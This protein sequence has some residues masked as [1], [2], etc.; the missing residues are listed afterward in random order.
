MA[1][2]KN[3]PLPDLA[4]R[5]KAIRLAMGLN[6]RDF[7]S[8]LGMIQ[9]SYNNSETGVSVPGMGLAV[10]LADRL[11]RLD[12]RW[13]LTGEGTMWTDG[14][15]SDGGSAHGLAASPISPAE[16]DRR[17]RLAY[18]GSG[19]GAVR[20][21]RI[22]AE[23]FPDGMTPRELAERGKVSMEALQADVALLEAHGVVVRDGL[24]YRDAGAGPSS[25]PRAWPTPPSSALR[26]SECWGRRSSPW[27]M[28]APGSW[29]L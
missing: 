9:S 21:W 12:T 28:T 15:G 10:R 29:A 6:Q 22:L 17:A 14:S 26:R 19:L 7:S 1:T 18:R 3:D 8:F 16:L 5:L 13:L 25:A 20:M 24:R 2:P 4:E 23:A 27:S 11:P